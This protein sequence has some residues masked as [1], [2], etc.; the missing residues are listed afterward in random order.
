[1]TPIPA[2]AARKSRRSTPC[3]A[4]PVPETALQS[5]NHIAKPLQ[6]C[7]PLAGRPDMTPGGPDLGQV[8]RDWYRLEK[9]EGIVSGPS[10]TAIAE[11][12]ETTDCPPQERSQRGEGA[13]ASDSEPNSGK[14]QAP[15]HPEPRPPRRPNCLDR[16]KGG[17]FQRSNYRGAANGRGRGRACSAACL[18]SVILRPHKARHSWVGGNPTAVPED[19]SRSRV[20][21][22][23]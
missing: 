19:G 16:P 17:R 1:M 14:S 13:E 5:G 22:R 18:D 3:P 20:L 15:S 7:P 6:Q 10:Q 21:N 12:C 11:P 2:W 23:R 4:R 8:E 9:V